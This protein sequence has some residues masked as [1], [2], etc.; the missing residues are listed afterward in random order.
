MPGKCYQALRVLGI[1]LAFLLGMGAVAQSLLAQEPTAPPTEETAQEPTPFHLGAYNFSGVT[2]FGYRFVDLNGNHAKYNQVFNLQQGFRVFDTQLNFLPREPNHRWF[3]RLSVTTQGLG[4][5]PHPVLRVDLRKNGIY[6]LRAGYRAKQYFYDLPE[7]PFTPHRGWIDRR[8]FADADL[9]YTPT[10][11]L[12][13][14]FFYNR[15]EREGNDLA[16]SSFF[17][18]PLAP[19]VWVDFGGSNLIPRVIP[20]REEMNLFGG[21]VDFR[22]GKTDVHLEQSY[23]TYNNPAKTK[24]LANQP[25]RLG[26]EMALPNLVVNRWDSL[27]EVN[28]PT[29]SLRVGQEVNGRLQWRGGYIYSHASGPTRFNG[30]VSGSNAFTLDYTGAGTTEMTTHTADGGFTLKLFEAMDLV[31]DYRYQTVGEKGTQ[32]L[33][34]AR[35]DLRTPVALSRDSLRWDFGIHTL[36]TLVAVVPRAS[37]SIRAGLRF[38]KQDIVRKRN[39]E[40][41]P[42]T[43]RSWYYTPLVNVAWTPSRKF[44]LRG[45]FESRVAVD[46]YVRLAA[47]NTVGSTIRARFYASD[48][49]GID[50]TWSFRNTKTEDIGFLAHARSNST[51]LWYQ[52]IK[53]LGFQGGF[54]YGSFSSENTIRFLLGVPSLTGLLSTDQTID[55]TYFL[56]V[57]I[58]PKST[59]TL[60]FSGQFIRSTGLGAFTGETSTPD[61]L[62]IRSTGLGLVTGA[63]STYGPLTWPAWDAEIAY[64]VN[65]VGRVV[66]SWQ[67]SYYYEDLFRATDYSANGFTLR[68]ER[69]F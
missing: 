19:E 51:S 63:T 32:S 5:D 69:S 23:R 61:P 56:G 9:R 65:R 18:L 20:T 47:E 15:T 57:K 1:F 13:L 26:D 33:Q 25:I 44:S 6:E 58:N 60:S 53:Q 11:D 50:N 45:D 64:T 24:G 52:P 22:L 2:S 41:A 37:L 36:D 59:L 40:I 39:G 17:F 54:M 68:F 28:I 8:R 49:W 43:R 7:T 4:G 14:R 3:D 67:R 29:T 30:S 35:S 21:G 48:R 31:S 27:A 34:A 46:P 10:R 55:R 38:L 16:T 12:R 62:I 42:G 66:F